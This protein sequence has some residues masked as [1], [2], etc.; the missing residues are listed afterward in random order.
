MNYHTVLFWLFHLDRGHN[1]RATVNA[2]SVEAHPVR[3]HATD[4][5]NDIRMSSSWLFMSCQSFINVMQNQVAEFRK[6]IDN[7]WWFCP[8]DFQ[9]FCWWGSRWN[10]NAFDPIKFSVR[11]PPKVSNFTRRGCQLQMAHWPDEIETET[12]HCCGIFSRQTTRRTA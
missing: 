9:G 6:P 3:V 8:R 10:Q 11:L 5:W 1:N 12:G 7:S 4:V 2:N